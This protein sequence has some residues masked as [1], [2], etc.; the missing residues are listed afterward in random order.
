M[1]TG[2]VEDVGKV[3]NLLLG[4]TNSRLKVQTNLKDIQI[5]DSVAVNGACLTVVKIE[6]NTLT[7]DLSEETLKR[8][9]LKWLKPNDLVN[10][11]RALTP[12]KPLGGH[13]VQGHVDTL[14]KITK[15]QKRGEHYLL[16]VEFEEEFLPY[17]VEKGSIAVDGISLTIN[18]VLPKG[19][20][21]NVIPHTFQN[22]NLKTRKEG[23]WVNLEFDILGKYVVNYLKRVVG[24]EEKLQ[25]WL[26]LF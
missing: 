14:G 16:Q 22:T 13:I 19:V 24:K 10:L 21:I 2:L 18:K 20:E 15:L 17:V 9:N 7:F 11:E 5:G 4:S 23:D 3:V 1:F 25:R 26:E 6:G 12:S 8:T